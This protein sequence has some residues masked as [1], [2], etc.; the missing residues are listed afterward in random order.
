LNPNQEDDMRVDEQDVTEQGFEEDDW[1]EPREDVE[2]VLHR[3][4][5]LALPWSTRAEDWFKTNFPRAFRYQGCVVVEP[6][7]LEKFL[8]DMRR[9]CLDVKE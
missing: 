1:V 3:G 5:I 7:D 8:A 4:L 6:G 9:D 2:M